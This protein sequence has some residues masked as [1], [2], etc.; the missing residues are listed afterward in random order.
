MFVAVLGLGLEYQIRIVGNTVMADA[1]GRE[2]V[3][4]DLIIIMMLSVQCGI[5]KAS[6]KVMVIY[7]M[8]LRKCMSFSK[9]SRNS[10]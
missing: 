3:G 4:F 5:W 1:K 6:L 7:E 10:N 8:S 2:G 9:C